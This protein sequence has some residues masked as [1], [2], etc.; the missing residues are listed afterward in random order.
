MNTNKHECKTNPNS[1]PCVFIRG[2]K[3]ELRIAGRPR[4]RNDVTNV[5]HSGQ[6]HQHAL[7]P[8]AET[9]VLDST[10]PAQVEIPPVALLRH[11]VAQD[12]LAQKIVALL[13]LA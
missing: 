2:S 5:F 10:E 1:C 4:E 7:E 3:S 11:A 6:I 9:G 12:A 13:A 8:H